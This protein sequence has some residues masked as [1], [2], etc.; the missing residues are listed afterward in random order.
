MSKCEGC[1]KYADCSS[2]SGLTWP[3]GAYVPRAQAPESIHTYPI[4]IHAPREGSDSKNSQNEQLFLRKIKHLSQISSRI[5]FYQQMHSSLPL[6]IRKKC[7]AEI[8]IF[9]V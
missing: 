3:C 8:L 9:S 6:Q 5:L 1:Q 4:S 2:G 7:G